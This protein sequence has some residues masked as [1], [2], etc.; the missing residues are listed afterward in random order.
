MIFV[1]VL[2]DLFQCLT[3]A[4]AKRKIFGGLSWQNSEGGNGKEVQSFVFGIVNCSKFLDE[5]SFKYSSPY[6]YEKFV[7]LLNL[8]IQVFH[9]QN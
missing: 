6:R 1:I 7:I 2:Y 4:G 8:P 5:R 3:E 9:L